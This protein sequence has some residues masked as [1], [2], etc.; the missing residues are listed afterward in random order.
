MAEHDVGAALHDELWAAL[1]N[2]R[3]DDVD[4][5]VWRLDA[6]YGGIVV[7]ARA[8][9]AQTWLVGLDTRESFLVF[10]T[11]AEPPPAGSRVRV[12]PAADDRWRFADVRRLG[13]DIELRLDHAPAPPDMAWVATLRDGVD[14][15][16]A[17]LE[18]RRSQLAARRAQL[19]A[20][21]E[22]P[23]VESIWREHVKEIGERVALETGYTPQEHRSLA[24]AR[25]KG[26]RSGDEEEQRI[27]TARRARYTEKRT[28]EVAR[29]RA[30]DWLPIRDRAAA[31]RAKYDTYRDEVIA[32][33]DALQR[34]R[35]T[36]ARAERALKL[37]DD[38]ERAEFAVGALTFDPSRLET[39]AYAQEM[40]RS[41]E[42]L[43]AAIPPRSASAAHF[44]AYRARTSGPA[45]SPPPRH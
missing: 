1:W 35:A 9:D 16:G 15:L 4:E 25:A 7:F 32:L 30:G 39:A 13:L 27:V 40:L 38:L 3:Y 43:H 24:K 11:G 18:A 20:M 31:A 29:F 17:L 2:R 21:T 23:A 34:V 12:L 28:A 45:V 10:R 5:P 6:S 26:V 8:L 37:L 14:R 22:P 42:L 36:A 33:E 19:G 41:I 44:S